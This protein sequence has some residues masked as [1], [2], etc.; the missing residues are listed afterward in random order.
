M[1]F[2]AS[3]HSSQPRR[4]SARSSRPSRASPI[5]VA[6]SRV[7]AARLTWRGTRADRTLDGPHAGEAGSSVLDA[8]KHCASEQSTTRGR[9]QINFEND[10]PRRRRCSGN[11]LHRV[12]KGGTDEGT[13]GRA[14]QSKSNTDPGSQYCSPSSS[15]AV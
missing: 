9:R 14:R 7:A 15:P 3:Q 2:K 6:R 8:L 4:Q 5:V 12:G 10:S 1:K 13:K 11:D